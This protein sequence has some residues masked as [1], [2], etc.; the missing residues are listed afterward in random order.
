MVRHLRLLKL[1]DIL[2]QLGWAR[3]VG[4]GCQG[5]DSDSE[6]KILAVKAWRVEFGSLTPMQKA[7]SCGKNKV[8]C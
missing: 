5:N 6:C 7:G 1:R 3:G 8:E 2:K 4:G